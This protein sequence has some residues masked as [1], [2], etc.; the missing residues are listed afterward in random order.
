MLT[1]NV[2]TPPANAANPF[3]NAPTT[4]ANPLANPG[5]SVISATLAKPA[6]QTALTNT[7]TS[8]PTSGLS[9]AAQQ[10]YN[11]LVS[12]GA[13]STAA[14]AAAKLVPTTATVQTPSS[15]AG[16]STTNTNTATP[17]TNTD[18]TTNTTN[19]NTAPATSII[20][21]TITNP[22]PTSAPFNTAVTGLENL[23]GSTPAATTAYE[24]AV[25]AAQPQIQDILQGAAQQEGSTL[26]GGMPATVAQGRAAGIAGV[27]QGEVGGIQSGLATLQGGSAAAQAQQQLQGTQYSSAGG[28]TQ[29]S[30]TYPF[31]FNPATGTYTQSTGGA[32][33]TT[34]GTV[35]GA[36]TTSQLTPAQAASAVNAG[37]MTPDQATSAL[38]YLGSTA[39]SQLYS[40]MNGINPN[41]NWN[42]A[43]QNAAVQ[44][45]LAPQVALAQS[46]IQNLQTTLSQAP[47]LQQTGIPAINAIAGWINGM[48]GNPSSK[49]LDDARS[50]A[51][52]AVE[53]ALSTAYGGTPTSYD[54]LISGWFPPNATPDQIGAGLAQFNA[55]VKYRSQAYTSPGATTLPTQNTGTTA[56]GAGSAPAGSVSYN[57]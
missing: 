8:S 54:N 16:A 6:A 35:S 14:L 43:T 37:T 47:S 13:S 10:Q 11:Q 4:P 48:L 33:G 9:A 30:G 41:F 7:Q 39:Q 19:T 55:L 50:T 21:P 53:T 3:A 40:A 1:S 52:S 20:S 34:G 49:A 18:P 36:S 2:V 12:A 46:E 57:F 44:G 17:V 15:V 42:Q 29:P 23:A 27:A 5:A 28:L 24:Q 56:S 51:V 45:T 31:V 22:T 38:S 25:A 32:A 26:T